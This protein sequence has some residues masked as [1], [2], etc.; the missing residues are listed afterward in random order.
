MDVSNLCW[1]CRKIFFPQKCSIFSLNRWCFG[2]STRWQSNESGLFGYAD[3]K[4][5]SATF[6]CRQ[7]WGAQNQGT[8]DT[9]L[10]DFVHREESADHELYVLSQEKCLDFDV[11]HQTSTNL[12]GPTCQFRQ[13]EIYETQWNG[14]F[15]TDHNFISWDF[16]LKFACY[17][18]GPEIR[19]NA[20]PTLWNFE[21]LCVK[22]CRFSGGINVKLLDA[23]YVGMWEGK[24][25]PFQRSSG[26]F[27]RNYEETGTD[28]EDTETGYKDTEAEFWGIRSVYKAATFLYIKSMCPASTMCFNKSAPKA[29]GWIFYFFLSLVAISLSLFAQHLKTPGV[30]RARLSALLAQREGEEGRGV[31]MLLLPWLWCD[32]LWHDVIWW[33]MISTW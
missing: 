25:L 21:V 13:S 12:E 17:I 20:S 15:L 9:P 32:V 6:P 11:D 33:N 26:R 8:V 18:S 5:M 14:I 2:E 24:V 3:S 29:L 31:L 19:F 7:I 28:I 16:H 27:E 23:C 4:K 10:R 22:P 1:F 30:S